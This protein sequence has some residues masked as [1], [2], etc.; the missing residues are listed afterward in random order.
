MA[1]AQQ[2]HAESTLEKDLA[3]HLAHI[4]HRR[5]ITFNSENDLYGGGT[6]RNYTNGARVTYFDLGARPPE[7]FDKVAALIPTFS[8]NPTTSI[9]YTLGHNLY[10]PKDITRAT[11]DPRDRPWAA[12]LYGAAG[13]VSV[14]GN[15]V[16]EI[17]ATLGVVG[18]M[19]LGRQVQTFVHE[20]ISDSP[21]PRG[22]RNQ[23][24]NEPGVMLAWQR[25]WPGRYGGEA[26]GFRA[27]AEPHFGLTLG[28]VYT[29][30][31]AG[32]NLSLSPYDGR[33]QDAPIRV[34]PAMPGTGAFIVPDSR[35]AWHL[36]GGIEGRAVARNIFLD[37]NTFRDSY[38]VDKHPLIADASAGVAFTYG[39]A[40]LSYAIVWR[41]PEFTKQDEGDVFGIVSLG[42]RY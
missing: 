11:Q 24:R 39:R 9:Y 26:L 38:R 32:L 5:F 37:G 34:R 21:T 15:H 41:S 18:P 2:S 7:I 35:F 33:F 27:G 31:G 23:I 12:F 14:T 25:R 22:W 13:L 36:F 10:T 4:K 17:E 6:D 8:I 30:A 1:L 29:Y 42:F 28:N 16:D 3:A 20:N 19:A 40:R